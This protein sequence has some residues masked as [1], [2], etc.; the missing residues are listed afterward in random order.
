MYIHR[1]G[2][3]DSAVTARGSRKVEWE[4]AR[5]RW[6]GRAKKKSKERKER[7][8]DRERKENAA[9]NKNENENRMRVC[10]GAS[11]VCMGERR[12]RDGYRYM[13]NKCVVGSLDAL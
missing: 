2:L 4:Q 5:E 6:K 9:E 12:E 13:V 11:G 3:I 8:R 10:R 7:D 1:H